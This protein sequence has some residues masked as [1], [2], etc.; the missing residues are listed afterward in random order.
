MLLVYRI[1]TEF[2]TLK[3]KKHTSIYALLF[4]SVFIALPNI[5]ILFLWTIIDPYHYVIRYIEHPGFLTVESE[6]RSKY[7]SVWIL[8][9][10][11]YSTL[12]L[13]GI[14]I[15]AIKSRNI[16]WKNFKDT[17]KVNILIFLYLFIRIS[18]LSYWAIIKTNEHYLDGKFYIFY[19]GNLIMAFLCQGF[20]F[21]PKVWPPVRDRLPKRCRH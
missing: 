4:Y 16:R 9:N 6:C 19:T 1:F 17:K 2:R 8:L 18:T 5:I 13:I 14:V 20:L 12:L 3:R 15:V 11:T 10:E 21:L 7:L